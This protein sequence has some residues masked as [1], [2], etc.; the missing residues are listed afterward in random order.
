MDDHPKNTRAHLSNQRKADTQT[1]KSVTKLQYAFIRHNSAHVEVRAQ[2]SAC[3]SLIRAAR[4]ICA[5][6]IHARAASVVYASAPRCTQNN[7]II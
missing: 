2:A 5:H 1:E 6:N 7:I 3:P 4:L